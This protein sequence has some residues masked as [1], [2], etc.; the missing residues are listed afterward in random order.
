[1]VSTRIALF[2][3]F[4]MLL[5]SIVASTIAPPA[6]LMVMPP[7]AMLA[8]PMGVVF[9]VVSAMVTSCVGAPVE[10]VEDWTWSPTCCS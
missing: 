5:P 3:A 6:G 8:L 4:W 9:I 10:P 7:P 1:M 2:L